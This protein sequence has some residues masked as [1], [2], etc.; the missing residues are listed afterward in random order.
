MFISKTYLKCGAVALFTMALI[1]NAIAKDD[2]T[3]RSITVEKE[4][5]TNIINA[6]GSFVLTDETVLTINEERAIAS[7]A[8]R[9][10][11]FNQTLESIKVTEAYTQ[12]PDGRKVQV[13]PDQIR[14]QQEPQLAGAPMFQDMRVKV[15][16]FPEVAVGDRLVFQYQK[17]RKTPMFPGNFEDLSAP[18]FVP[19][20]QFSLIY[21]VPEGMRLYSEAVGFTPSSPTAKAGRKIYRWDYQT[22]ENARIEIGSVAYIDYGSRLMVSTF[23]DYASFAQA[24]DVRAKEKSKPVPKVADLA[25]KITTD[26][27]DPRAQALALAEWVKK[28]IRYVAVYIG[29]GG[30]VPHSSDTIL[31]NLYGDCKDHATLLEAMLSAVGIDSTPVLINMGTSY[32]LPKVPTL[33]VFNHAITYVPSLDLYLDSTNPALASGYLAQAEWD[34][35]ALLTRSGTVG[36]TPAVQPTM[37]LHVTEFKVDAKGET[38]YTHSSTISAWGAEPRRYGFRQAHPTDLAM[39]PERVLQAYGLKGG[40]ILDIG[41]TN[42]KGDDY[43]YSFSGHI[44]NLVNLPGPVGVPAFTGLGG[45]IANWVFPTASEKERTQMYACF[46]GETKE[47]STFLFAKEIKILGVPKAMSIHDANFDY[48]SEYIQDANT[49]VV[50]RHLSFHHKGAVCTPEDFKAIRPPL[51]L[52]I[53]DLK[54]QVVV[55]GT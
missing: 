45:G 19:T 38:D 34:K 25:K 54:G 32:V 44:E 17:N 27:S 18:G 30:V 55:Q 7:Q 39:M 31:E 26:I 47:Q 21:D 6:D 48:T 1:G 10:I 24:Y 23:P 28:N 12:K 43:K 9:S 40:G 49:V 36:H 14:E 53:R 50:K 42:G 29:A 33:G 52:M 3:D 37:N 2:G 22:S 41:D 5:Q 11:Y 16:I 46:S 20:K 35:P 4:I 8:Q 13:K 15:V 51:D